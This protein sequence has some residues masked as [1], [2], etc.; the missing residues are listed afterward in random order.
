M[1]AEAYMELKDPRFIMAV[2]QHQKLIACALAHPLAAKLKELPFYAFV[3]PALL[4]ERILA[5]ASHAHCAIETDFSRMDG[6]ISPA[7]RE[8]HDRALLFRVFRRFT[9]LCIEA[10][11]KL[12]MQHVKIKDIFKEV[13]V[14][15]NTYHAQ[16]TGDGF[17]SVLH[18]SR[19]A[20]VTY[21]TLRQCGR[22]PREAFAE[23]GMKG[24]DDGTSFLTQGVSSSRF[25]ADFK[26]VC[27]QMGLSAKTTVTPFGS[28]VLFCARYWMVWDGEA[29][30]MTDVGRYMKKLHLT[31]DKL[32]KP[33]D[34]LAQKVA[35]ALITDKNTPIV[36]PWARYA[37]KH[38]G[39]GVL[40]IDATA[41][42]YAAT[43]TTRY[44]NRRSEWM[45]EV[46]EKTYP[47]FDSA[48]FMKAMSRGTNPLE[49]P[50]CVE[51]HTHEHAPSS[52]PAVV[53][54]VD[55]M[56]IP[57]DNGSDEPIRIRETL[58]TARTGNTDPRRGMPPTDPRGG[59]PS[60]A[61]GT[62]RRAGAEPLGGGQR[63]GTRRDTSSDCKTTPTAPTTGTRHG[64][65]PRQGSNPGTAPT[66]RAA[67]GR[68][69]RRH[70]RVDRQ[71]VVA[72]NQKAQNTRLP[73]V[74]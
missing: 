39:R 57:S 70:G 34:K 22:S 5:C 29:N 43:F 17:T 46:I 13:L 20:M 41:E 37:S 55:Q 52:F 30:S 49:F 38:L 33:V 32:S 74:P 59:T 4:A 19:N 51:D 9:K 27:S 31:A 26:Y 14:S 60:V 11:A 18:T 36:G 2:S 8:L 63:A 15:F 47:E 35:A 54:G 44:P 50:L 71:P 1:K 45:L 10:L 48:I 24:G 12:Q 53:G 73:Q 65:G 69:D 62:F 6:T 64:G 7:M 61:A 66:S 23:I 42:C 67:R 68:P 25:C 16:L 21:A 3:E 58:K 56:V 40:K 28:P 72:T